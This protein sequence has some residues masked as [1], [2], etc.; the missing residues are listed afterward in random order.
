MKEENANAVVYVLKYLN[1]LNII[2]NLI[3]SESK[4][5]GKLKQKKKS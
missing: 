3:L 5:V 1:N 2:I 4:S